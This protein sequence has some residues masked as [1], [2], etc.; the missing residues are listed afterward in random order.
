MK[1]YDELVKLTLKEI[2]ETWGAFREGRITLDEYSRRLE[3]SKD[4]MVEYAQGVEGALS[5]FKVM[6]FVTRSFALRSVRVLK[7][8]YGLEVELKEDFTVSIPSQGYRLK[9]DPTTRTIMALGKEKVIATEGE[10]DLGNV[11]NSVK[12]L[13]NHIGLLSKTH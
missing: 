11:E 10:V 6:A 13:M 3:V 4:V 9:F 1:P 7:D 2:E 8:A 12:K 5:D